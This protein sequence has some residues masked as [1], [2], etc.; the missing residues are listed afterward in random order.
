MP[1]VTIR[2]LEARDEAEWRRLWT[3]YLDFYESKV[4][5]EVYATS[6][7]RMLSGAA[8]EV[9]GRGHMRGAAE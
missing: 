5:E 1:A 6:F 9:R 7:A 8:G 3:A 4:P 2:P